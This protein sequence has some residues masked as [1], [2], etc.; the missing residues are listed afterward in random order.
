MGIFTL[1][2]VLQLF[3]L[4]GMAYAAEQVQGALGT[5]QQE[6]AV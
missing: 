1:S 3:P 5:E 6:A 4:Q 2:L